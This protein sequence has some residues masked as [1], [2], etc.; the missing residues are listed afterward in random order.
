MSPFDIDQ[1][2]SFKPDTLE[3]RVRHVSG[4]PVRATTV[5]LTRENC[6]QQLRDIQTI[7]ESCGVQGSVELRKRN[8]AGTAQE[9]WQVLHLATAIKD[10]EE[11]AGC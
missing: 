7:V 8:A 5:V 11:W 4:S 1:A 3:I 6:K 9:F 2:P 10:A